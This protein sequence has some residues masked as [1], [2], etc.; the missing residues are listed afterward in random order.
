M[1]F[2]GVIYDSDSKSRENLNGAFVSQGAGW[3]IPEG[4][5]WMSSNN[6]PIPFDIEKLKRFVVAM[7]NFVSETYAK[8]F[9]MKMTIKTM[10]ENGASDQ[11]ILNFPVI[12]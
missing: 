1:E 2:E 6:T 12:F 4:F 9:V 11:D 7:T 3:V 8:S 5:V 10:A